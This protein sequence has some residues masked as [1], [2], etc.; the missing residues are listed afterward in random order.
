LREK[1]GDLDMTLNESPPAVQPVLADIN[2]PKITHT[3]KKSLKNL[4]KNM[5]IAP[6]MIFLY[7][8]IAE[9]KGSTTREKN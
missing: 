8:C 7:L 9:R 4:L 1:A 6:G 3:L 5:S 2:V